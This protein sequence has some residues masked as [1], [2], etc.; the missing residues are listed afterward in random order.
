MF[1]VSNTLH[2]DKSSD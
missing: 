1:N 2:K